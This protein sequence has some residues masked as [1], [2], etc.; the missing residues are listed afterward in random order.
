MD[1]QELIR[2]VQERDHAA[3]ERLMRLYERR[4]M[5]LIRSLIRNPEDAADVF[6]EV[7]I[8]VYLG[9]KRFRLESSFYTWLYRIAVNRCLTWHDQRSR[10]EKLHATPLEGGEEDDEWLERTIHV[11]GLNGDGREQDRGKT[12]RL[13]KIWR[14]VETLN[15]KQRL[16]F[17]LRYQHGMQV[18]EISEIF[19]MP[20]GTVKILAFRAIRHIRAQLKDG[21]Q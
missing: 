7:F 2:L 18:K 5:G 10:R 14:A 9:I 8:R 13:Q 6:Q 4:I 1:E 12:E 11:H 3:F 19:D 16:I 17:C 21:V 20:D 15:A